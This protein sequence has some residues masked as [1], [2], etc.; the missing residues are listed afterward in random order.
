MNGSTTGG[1]VGSYVQVTA[2]ES[3][4]YLVT[5][6]LLLGSGTLATPFSDT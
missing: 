6:S 5:N 2:L 1:I 4:Q 3:A